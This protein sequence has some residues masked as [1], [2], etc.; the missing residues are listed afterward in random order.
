MKKSKS[1]IIGMTLDAIKEVLLKEYYHTH[2]GNLA[3]RKLIK[4]VDIDSVC[5]EVAFFFLQG[6]PPKGYAIWVEGHRTITF[7]QANLKPFYI[8]YLPNGIMGIN[9]CNSIFGRV[10]TT[11]NMSGCEW[12]V[13]IEEQD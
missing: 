7:Y 12:L 11:D 4:L 13:D 10:P 2:G 5:D 9:N 1:S 6:S 8:Q 3:S